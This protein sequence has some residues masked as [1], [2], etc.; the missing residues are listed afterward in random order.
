MTARVLSADD[1][2]PDQVWQLKCFIQFARDA[3]DSA[4]LARDALRSAEAD[5]AAV[6]AKCIPQGESLHLPDLGCT[7]KWLP[8][9]T[10]GQPIAFV[11][12][13]RR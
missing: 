1:V 8:N 7:V 11:V 9:V 6:L 10:S 3:A 4:A 2:A 12:P 5:L 13:V